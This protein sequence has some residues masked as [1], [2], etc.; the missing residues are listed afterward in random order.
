[1]VV[2]EKASPQLVPWIGK[3]TDNKK[4]HWN[5]L[6][7]DISCLTVQVFLFPVPLPNYLYPF[8]NLFQLIPSSKFEGTKWPETS[9]HS[10]WL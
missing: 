6:S 2:V 4:Q 9:N 10:C 1:M 5:S 8:P 3:S 7:R